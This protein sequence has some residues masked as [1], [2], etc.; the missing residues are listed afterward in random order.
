MARG[1]HRYHRANEIQTSGGHVTVLVHVK[2]HQSKFLMFL[3][4]VGG[5]M[6]PDLMKIHCFGQMLLTFQ[7]A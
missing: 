2:G 3:I 6:K 4:A 7:K 1:S 5:H